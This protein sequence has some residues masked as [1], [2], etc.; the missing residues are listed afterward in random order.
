MR[1][2][3]GRLE[4]CV[5]SAGKAHVHKIP[6]FGGVGVF[7]VFF[8]GGGECRF[9]FYGRADFSDTTVI[10]SRYTVATLCRITFSR[11]CSGRG[12]AGESRYTPWKQVPVAS[13]FSALTRGVALQ[14]A[15]W[16]VSWYTGGCRSYTVACRAAVGHLAYHSGH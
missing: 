12:V 14:V 15:S 13:T 16:K 4:K 3:Y 11:I 1:Q 6:R 10:L 8:W 2:F 5:L 9:Y 7:W